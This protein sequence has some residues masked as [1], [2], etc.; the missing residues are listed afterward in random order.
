M[1]ILP[2]IGN[3]V[4]L[5]QKAYD[6]I[7]EA[8]LTN[9]LKPGELLIEEKLAEQLEISRTPLRSALKMLSYDHLVTIN[10]SRNVMVTNIDQGE[11]N[12][13]AVVRKALETTAVMELKS[14]ITKGEIKEL[15]KI[16]TDQFEAYE[17]K[18]YDELIEMEYEFHVKIAK[19]TKNKWIYD[20]VKT[21]NTVVQRYLVLSGSLNKYARVAIEEHEEIVESIKNGEFEK[22]SENMKHHII[23]VNDRMLK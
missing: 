14:N 6:A 21:S 2:K 11:L 19:Y 7:K 8:I 12:Q 5:T 1:N 23:N 18:N 13:I 10:S 20:M 4:S 9:K 3:K 22:A 16:V 15:G 17:H